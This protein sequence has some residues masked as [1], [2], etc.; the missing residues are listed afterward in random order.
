MMCVN[1]CKKFAVYTQRDESPLELAS[2]MDDG[3]YKMNM[4]IVHDNCRPHVPNDCALV[5]L[6]FV[7]RR[8]HAKNTVMRIVAAIILTAG[9]GV[10]SRCSQVSAMY[11]FQALLSLWPYCLYVSTAVSVCD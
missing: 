6:P 2:V 1:S 11:F 3:E 10:R 7:R 8:R 9:I 5:T 4:L